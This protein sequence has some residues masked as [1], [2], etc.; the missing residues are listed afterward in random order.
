MDL[1][2]M[3]VH[4]KWGGVHLRPGDDYETEYFTEGVQYRS[5]GKIGTRSTFIGGGGRGQ[6]LNSVKKSK[7]IS[8]IF[9]W[10]LT[11]L[12]LTPPPIFCLAEIE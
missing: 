3:D 11:F 1:K 12:E 5:T 10:V 7:S 2:K 8:G 9:G 4:V 6:F